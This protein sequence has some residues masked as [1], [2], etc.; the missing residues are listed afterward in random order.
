MLGVESEIGVCTNCSSVE[1]NLCREAFLAKLSLAFA[2]QIFGFKFKLNDSLSDIKT[3]TA[4]FE[5]LS[6]NFY[7]SLI[8][9]V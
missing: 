4:I 8:V 3:C 6:L 5:H 1:E 7:L 9:L 2:V